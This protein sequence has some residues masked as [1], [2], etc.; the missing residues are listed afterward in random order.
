LNVLDPDATVRVNA[1]TVR[2]ADLQDGDLVQ[3]G[4]TSW[5]VFRIIPPMPASARRGSPMRAT[6]VLL[7][8]VVVAGQLAFLY[9]ISSRWNSAPPVTT[10]RPPRLRR[11]SPPSRQPPRRTPRLP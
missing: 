8:A 3:V 4:E 11:S 6:T 2:Q 7:L 5:N 10:A 9:W 1:A